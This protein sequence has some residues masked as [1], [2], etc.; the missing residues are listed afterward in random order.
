MTAS[1][2]TYIGDGLYVSHDGFQVCLRAP[3]PAGDHE[4]YLEPSTLIEF[5]RW[6]YANGIDIPQREK[7]L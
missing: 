4:V 2:E 7:P 3:R 1:P 5:A 6:C